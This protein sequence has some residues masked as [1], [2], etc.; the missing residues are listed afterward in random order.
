LAVTFQQWR[1][2]EEAV[3][4]V[5]Q[6][7]SHEPA[8]PIACHF[9]A[10][11]TGR[12]L[13]AR[14]ADEYIRSTFDHFAR[15]FDT[16]LQH[17][18]YHAPEMVAAA[19]A[20]ALGGPQG[21]LDVL[22]AGCGTGWCG[23][24]L[25]PYAGRLSG[26]DLSPAMLE[27]ARARQVYDH[28]IEGELTAHLQAAAD[29]YDL[30]ASADT[31]VYFGDLRPVFAAAAAALRRGGLLIFTLERAIRDDAEG[32][33]FFLQRH[34]RYCHS[35]DYVR[36]RLAEAGLSIREMTFG[37]LR[38]ELGEAVHGILATACKGGAS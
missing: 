1:R 12:D 18:E 6:W 23:P 17:L 33:G 9:L 16:K 24:L 21:N 25:R 31:L 7:L 34:G 2:T 30:V 29:R 27:R 36:S 3:A 5:E 11:Y 20:K 26:V 28:L 10:A 37:I 14:A 32:Q 4:V 19:V 15:T 22:D 35:E 38:K 13:P 8:S